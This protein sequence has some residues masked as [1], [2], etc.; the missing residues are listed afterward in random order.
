M[1]TIKVKAPATVANL[2]CGFDVLGLCVDAP[3]DVMEVQLLD[4]KEIIIQSADN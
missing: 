3:Y 2:V 1:T 4:R